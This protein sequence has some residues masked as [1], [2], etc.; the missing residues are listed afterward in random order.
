MKTDRNG[1]S[2]AAIL[3]ALFC[4]AGLA[5]LPFA[6]ASPAAAQ[7]DLTL[8]AE[9]TPSPRFLLRRM[10]RAETKRAV[11]GREVTSLAGGRQSEQ[12]VKRD[13][14]RGLRM[15]F[16]APPG[17]ILVDNFKRSWFLSL[18][19]RRMVERESRLGGLRRAT[20]EVV[21]RIER[22]ELQAQWDG[23]DVVAGRDADIVRVSPRGRSDAPSRRFW[24]DRE[25]GLRLKT[26]DVGPRG[27]VLS[28]SYFL[29]VDLRPDLTKADFERPDL[30]PGVRLVRDNKRSFPSIQAA[31]RVVKFSLRQ[32]EYLPPGFRLATVSVTE[33]KGHTVVVQRYTNGLNSLSVFQ[34]DADLPPFGL[35]GRKRRGPMPPGRGPRVLTWRDRD[36]AFALIGSLPE[37]EM[38]RIADSLR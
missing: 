5:A 35:E 19:R 37:T 23:R 3:A 33:F 29:T 16:I 38:R 10:L 36:R 14:K 12:I 31:Q 4:G 21:Q 7:S 30:P 17:D 25:T 11:A 1:I 27:R 9:Q 13:P 22:G 6:P 34:T 8:A 26:E 20:Q 32:P 2:R 28:S 18:R 15:E 24:I